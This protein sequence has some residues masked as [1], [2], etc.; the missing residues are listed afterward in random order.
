MARSNHGGMG[1]AAPTPR[2]AAENRSPELNQR[3]VVQA[4]HRPQ[5]ILRGDP[6]L[7]VEVGGQRPVSLIFARI[8]PNDS[9]R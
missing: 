6:R 5:R 4:A 3:R 8:D 7:D 2:R 9:T 1:T